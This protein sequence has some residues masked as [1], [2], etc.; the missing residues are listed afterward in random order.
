MRQ[1]SA[2]AHTRDELLPD[3]HP[4]SPARTPTADADQ[5]QPNTTECSPGPD[6][7]N[8][9]SVGRIR[10]ITM[11]VGELVLWNRPAWS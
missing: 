9:R 2:D 10:L 4:G 11:R 7:I 1:Q 3:Q 8:I 6:M 5:A